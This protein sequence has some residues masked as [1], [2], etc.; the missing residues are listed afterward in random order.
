MVHSIISGEL[1]TIHAT[2]K[3]RTIKSFY[4]YASQPCNQDRLFILHIKKP[5][6]AGLNYF[7]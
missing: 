5:A 2:N 3:L 6:E 1:L 4:Y 7:F